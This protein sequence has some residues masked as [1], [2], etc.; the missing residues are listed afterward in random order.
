MLPAQGVQ[1]PP[2]IAA[3]VEVLFL[4]ACTGAD[5]PSQSVRVRHVEDGHP[6]ALTV[7]LAGPV[8]EVLAP[9]FRF[10]VAGGRLPP[11]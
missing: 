3:A 5:S 7:E 10:R 2:S 6:E 1:E 9:D 11:R 8:Q 4:C